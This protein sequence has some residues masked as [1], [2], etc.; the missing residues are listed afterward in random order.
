MKLGF[1]VFGVVCAWSIAAHAG[2]DKAVLAP[3]FTASPKDL[4]S[5]ASKVSAGNAAVV[6]L[7]RENHEKYDA[8]GRAVSRFRMIYVVT[9]QAGI[10]EWGTVSTAWKPFYQDKPVIR[11]RVIDPSGKVT[12]IDQSLLHDAPA[13]SASPTVF[14][15]LRELVAPLPR[16]QIGAVVEQEITTTDR[17]PLLEAG[18]I[19]RFTYAASLPVQSTGLVLSVPSSRKAI[20]VA[21]SMKTV[22]KRTTVNGMDTWTLE[23]GAT[24]PDDSD[25][26]SLPS[27]V[28]EYPFVGIAT[29]ASWTAIARDYAMILERRLV[30][31][32]FALP[33]TLKGPST[34][35]TVNGIVAWLHAQIRYTGIEFGQASITPWPPAETVKRGF[36]DC[37]DKAIL[38]VTLLRQA[39]FRADLA[40]LSTGPGQDVD[41]A[42]PGLG[43]FDHAIVRVLVGGKP[44]WIDATE[45]LY[46]AGALPLRDQGRRA[47]IVAND[48]RDLVFT[49]RSKS[50]DTLIR[51][52]RTFT[53]AEYGPARVVEVSR[54][55]GMYDV[56]NRSWI[57]DTRADEVRD[58]LK[59]YATTEYAGELESWTSTSPADLATPFE[60]T[61]VVAK[62]RRAFSTREKIDVTLSPAD[63]LEKMPSDLRTFDPKAKPRERDFE[64]WRPHRYEIE[65]RLVVPKGFTMP[66]PTPERTRAFGVASLVER[67][68][69]DGDTFVVTYLFDSGKSRLTAKELTETA[70]A[71]ADLG[72]EQQHVTF[73]QTGWALTDAGKLKEGIASIEELIRA[74]PKEGLHQYQLARAYLKAGAGQA[75]RRAARRGLQLEP[76]DADGYAMLAWILQFDSFGRYLG[77]DSD[78]AGVI[79]AY[80]KAIELDPK[81]A[82]LAKGLGQVFSTGPKGGWHGADLPNAAKALESAFALEP[83]DDLAN[84]LARVYLRAN[85]F[86]DA[87]RVLRPRESALVRDALL[88]SAIALQR[89]GAAAISFAGQVRTDRSTV[90]DETGRFLI[91]LRNYDLGRELFKATGSQNTQQSFLLWQKVQRRPAPDRKDPKWSVREMF[92]DIVEPDPSGPA[93]WDSTTRT[94]ILANNRFPPSLK[95]QLRSVG[96]ELWQDFAHTVID[97]KIDGPKNGPWKATFEMVGKKG[98]MYVALDRGVAKVIGAQEAIE[99]L[100]RHAQRDAANAERLLDWARAEIDAGHDTHMRF[101]ELWGPGK[102]RDA[103]A[104]A[105]AAAVLAGTAGSQQVLAACATSAPDARKQC[106]A[107]LLF[108]LAQQRKWAELDKKASTSNALESER[109]YLRAY[110]LANLGRHDEG[111]KV[112]AELAS[113]FAAIPFVD[114]ARLEAAAARKDTRKLRDL[115]EADLKKPTPHESTKNGYAWQLLADGQDLPRALELSRQAV[116][117][118]PNKDF[119]LNTLGAVAAEMGDLQTAVKTGGEAMDLDSRTVPEGQDWLLFATVYE[120]L[121]LRDDAIAAYKRVTDK[122]SL[123]PTSLDIAKARLARMGAK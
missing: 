21:R 122:P 81:A 121:G 105:V 72:P 4:L 10:D 63:A 27:D 13:V 66:A 23:L 88:L 117:E 31:G 77:F 62:S 93:Y 102:P 57:R 104:A 47:L 98:N 91:M 12:E 85:R 101:A 28:V 7:R 17:E 40:L 45:D 59:D 103:K 75:A 51:E 15:D 109:L 39:G 115:Y 68:R 41:T 97:I 67:Q 54:E 60:I 53:L 99:G 46:L 16:L 87:E 19:D 3:P 32:P 86:A 76:K 34:L 80:R 89:G 123:H 119:V 92:A 9:S 26:S 108:Q 74:H 18:T 70:K 50:S 20:V 36:G 43:E 73:P 61:M 37:K 78:R 94:E 100:G 114:Q 71:L 30:D 33:A 112:I 22:P 8:R 24:A 65:N 69:V 116:V 44:V 42:L 58:S 111:D 55:A 1:G 83:D 48:T 35:A 2:P 107:M 49:P 82:Y 6:I 106:D 5:L 120:K 38:L 64:L 84:D 90:L 96:E 110:A 14:S 25:E 118:R 113:K 11:A 95:N 56:D 79:A 52:V 29:G